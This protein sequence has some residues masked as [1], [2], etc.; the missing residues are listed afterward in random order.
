MAYR[1]ILNQIFIKQTH[2]VTPY[3]CISGDVYCQ[4]DHPLP[5]RRSPGIP[6]FWLRSAG[7][8]VILS[9]NGRLDLQ[10]A[11]CPPPLVWRN[12][13]RVRSLFTTFREMAC[14]SCVDFVHSANDGIAPQGRGDGFAPAGRSPLRGSLNGLRSAVPAALLRSAVIRSVRSVNT[15]QTSHFAPLRSLRSPPPS[16]P[17]Q[18]AAPAKTPVSGQN[19]RFRPK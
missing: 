16:V 8:P 7:R 1:Q 12:S 4:N 11:F 10:P 6:A 18:P 2:G 9:S 3:Q 13:G 14:L 5:K 15:L 17:A 19:D